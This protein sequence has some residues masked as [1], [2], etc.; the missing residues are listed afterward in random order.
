[1]LTTDSRS[2]SASSPMA[3]WRF[4]SSFESVRC[5]ARIARRAGREDDE[6]RREPYRIHDRPAGDRLAEQVGW[7]QG[8]SGTEQGHGNARTAAEPPAGRHGGEEQ[9]RTEVGRAG[10]DLDE[11]AE[12]DHGE[13]R[14]DT[15]RDIRAGD[16]I[17]DLRL[18][19]LRVVLGRDAGRGRGRSAGH[20]PV[21]VGQPDGHALLPFLEL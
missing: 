14:A 9:E 17:V 12:S 10:G 2:W 13:R 16:R 21:P 19:D 3:A 18:G 8:S 4:A 20:D 1:M 6:C 11:R 5:R 7:D 15:D